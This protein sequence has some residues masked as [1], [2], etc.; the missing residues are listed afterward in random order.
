M[1]FILENVRNEHVLA[2]RWERASAHKY[3][4]IEVDHAPFISAQTKCGDTFKIRSVVI[5]DFLKLV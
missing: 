2:D 3:L 5:K 1:Y 4:K